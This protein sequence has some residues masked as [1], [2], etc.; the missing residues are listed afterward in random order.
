MFSLSEGFYSKGANIIMKSKIILLSSIALSTLAL[1]GCGGS[2]KTKIG[3]L[4]PVEHSALSAARLGFQAA[5]GLHGFDKDKVE[6][7]YHNAGQSSSDLASLAKDLV[8]R[9]DMTFGIGTGAAQAL[10]SAAID[11]GKTNPILFSAVTDPVGAG[12]VTSLQ[13]G[14][15]FITGTSDINPV[16]AQVSLIRDIN[17]DADKAAIIYTQTE[18]NSKVQADMA[19]AELEKEGFTVTIKTCSGPSDISA[20][21]TALVAEEGLDAIF[22]PTDNNIAAN[23]SAIKSAVQGKGVIVVA[24]EESIMKECGSITLSVDYTKLGNMTGDMAASILKGDKKAGEIPVGFMG[25]DECEYV[26]STANAIAAGVTLPAE[27]VAKCRDVSK[28]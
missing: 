8:G 16:E 27:I 12:L 19:K 23:P 5:L 24:G 22:V 18:T 9:C 2:S 20:V 6:F 28:N 15:G 1:A 10:K 3:I 25:K 17:P 14:S 13:N 7:I 4:Q 26:C 11:K 21:A